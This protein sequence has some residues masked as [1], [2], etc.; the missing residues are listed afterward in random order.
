MVMIPW[1]NISSTAPVTPMV[2][3]DMTPSV[4]KLICASEEYATKR[5]RSLETHARI[6]PYKMPI[7]ANVKT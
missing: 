6:E 7:T 2:E 1:L 4:M 5:L 3:P